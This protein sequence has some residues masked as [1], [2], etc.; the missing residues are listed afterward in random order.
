MYMVYIRYSIWAQSW[1][2][3]PPAPAWKVR[4][5]LRL[6]YSPVRRVERVMASI[7]FWR[8]SVSRRDRKSV[9]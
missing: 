4:M 9:V 1:A 7:S 2:S 5:A 8:V 3:V 6:S